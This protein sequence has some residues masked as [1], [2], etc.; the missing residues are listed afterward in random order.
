VNPPSFAVTTARCSPAPAAQPRS[1]G[2][3]GTPAVP[4]VDIGPDRSTT[5]R[6]H[7]AR[8]THALPDARV[9]RSVG[10]ALRS[11]PGQH[12]GVSGEPRRERDPDH[13]ASAGRSR[14]RPNRAAAP[15]PAPGHRRPLCRDEGM[16][17][18]LRSPR[19][20]EPRGGH[21]DRVR[22][23]DGSVRSD[24]GP[25]APRRGLGVGRLTSAPGQTR[26]AGGSMPRY[27]GALGI[28]IHS[29]T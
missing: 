10:G 7:R 26:P 6:D 24:R 5:M 8:E 2:Q 11:R 14:R 28:T 23:S 3:A 25:T 9:R 13:G 27:S 15:G 22:A 21:S 16:D 12:P 17:R 19:V 1:A 29:T 4:S 20:R 18:G